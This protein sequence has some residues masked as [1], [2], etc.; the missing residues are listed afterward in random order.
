MPFG[1][2]AR[3]LEKVSTTR[4]QTQLGKAQSILLD[5]LDI[6]DKPVARKAENIAE[7][8]THSAVWVS[9]EMERKI[10]K[11]AS[12]GGNCDSEDEAIYFRLKKDL[13]GIYSGGSANWTS[14]MVF[15]LLEAAKEYDDFTQEIKE[16][17]D[18]DANAL[19]INSDLN[20]SNFKIGAKAANNLYALAA[21]A[22]A[23]ETSP[24]AGEELAADT[25]ANRNLLADSLQKC[26][27]LAE[28]RKR[29]AKGWHRN[30]ALQATH[31]NTLL[32][33]AA[34]LDEAIRRETQWAEQV[35]LGETAQ[36]KTLRQNAAGPK[37]VG[38]TQIGGM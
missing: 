7:G 28:S 34:E 12:W 38:G 15:Q 33:E 37:A 18:L 25:E 36:E 22:P 13:V 26:K 5:A 4:G 32:A 11:D 31:T 29:I 1:M 8:Y 20:F 30:R 27:L 21:V 24:I 2:K 19:E 6:P 23:G 35:G 16:R 10:R 14:N 9:A 3:K 17:T